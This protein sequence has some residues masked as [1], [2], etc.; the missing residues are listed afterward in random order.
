MHGP[1]ACHAASS[2]GKPEK[3]E[4]HLKNTTEH[5][6]EVDGILF[7]NFMTTSGNNRQL[8]KE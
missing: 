8:T 7:Y 1:W 5:D 3:L 6:L 2:L 4:V